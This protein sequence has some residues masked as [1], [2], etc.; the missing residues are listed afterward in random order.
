VQPSRQ[1]C[2]RRGSRDGPPARV[3]SPRC[4][5]RAIPRTRAGY[6]PASGGLGHPRLG[7]ATAAMARMGSGIAVTDEGS[8][9][10]ARSRRPLA[11]VWLGSLVAQ[12][13]FARVRLDRPDRHDAPTH[14]TVALPF[15]A[16]DSEAGGKAVRMASVASPG[17]TAS[18]Q[19]I[20]ASCGSGAR[21]PSGAPW[22]RAT[23]PAPSSR[24]R[25]R[26]CRRAKQ[27]RQADRPQLQ[28]P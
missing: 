18:A 13:C 7:I 17:V 8:L 16:G 23:Y 3:R 21:S 15:P 10:A 5:Q 14:P 19:P 25:C 26:C 27:L 11:G 28:P 24:E 22:S 9:L 1:S 20:P 12:S 6:V 4:Q 2:R